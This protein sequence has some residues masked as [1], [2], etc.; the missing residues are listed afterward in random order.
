MAQL[1]DFIEPDLSTSDVVHSNGYAQAASDGGAAVSGAGSDGMSM[2]QRKEQMYNSRYV[3]G[4]HWSNLGKRYGAV[5]ARTVGQQTGRAYDAGSD[6]FSDKAGYS[7][8]RST[9]TRGGRP[10]APMPA[11]Q[12]HFVE[13][14]GRT[15]NPYA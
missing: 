2:Q 5:K 6:T 3:K 13:P 11:P 8:R 10:A 12:R 14:Q 4:Y 15:H 7:I 1:S 9:G